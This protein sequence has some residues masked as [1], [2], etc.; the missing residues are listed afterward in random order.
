MYYYAIPILLDSGQWIINDVFTEEKEIC[1]T[2]MRVYRKLLRMH[3]TER[4]GSFK[5]NGIDGH[6]YL[7][8]DELVISV[9]HNQE[10]GLGEFKPHPTYWRKNVLRG[11]VS[12]GKGN[13]IDKKQILGSCRG[14]QS[15]T[16]METVVISNKL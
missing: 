9:A 16:E 7:K 15:Y 2:D 3:W 1:T 8:E 13:N 10:R 14:P 12:S 5:K 4:L 11:D 6:L